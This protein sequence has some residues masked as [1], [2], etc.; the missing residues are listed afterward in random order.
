M[1]S[2]VLVNSIGNVVM[3]IV[4]IAAF[5][6]LYNTYKQNNIHTI[7]Y[8]CVFFGFF[9]VFQF[10][11]SFRYLFEVYQL[12]VTSLHIFSQL[13]LYI[14]LAYFSRVVIYIVKPDWETRIF[15]ALLIYGVAAVTLMMVLQEPIAPLIAIPALLVWVGLGT[16]SFGHMAWKREGTDRLKMAL[17]AL[18]FF[19]MA[20]A[21]PL[22]NA[23]VI[24]ENVLLLSFVNSFTVIGTLIAL[25][26]IYYDYLIRN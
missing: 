17:L 10:F 20:L 3:T 1:I 15:Q 13:F 24:Q 18:G 2:S 7:K 22:H 8:L 9:G 14:A 26:G 23:P 12:P 25:T 4:A 5:Y 21:G 11:L 6:K 16:V 19:V